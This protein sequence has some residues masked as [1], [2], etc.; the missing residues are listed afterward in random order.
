MRSVTIAATGAYLPGEPLSNADLECLVGPLPADVLDGIQVRERHWMVDPSTGEHLLSN[1]EMA[2]AAGLRALAS[3]GLKPRD[4]DLLV[5]STA[6]PDF[7]LPPMATL[8]QDHLGIRACTA[9]ELR[10]GSAGAVEALDLARAYIERGSHEVALVIGS[11]AISP[12][13]VP[14][15]RGRDPQRIRMRDRMTLY[16][17]GDGA[18]AM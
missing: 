12:L 14:I 5:V 13:L 18:G 1:S 16:T 6:S 15:F 11:E 7:Q 4:V 3:A 8:V 9:L 2:A 10:S 17:F